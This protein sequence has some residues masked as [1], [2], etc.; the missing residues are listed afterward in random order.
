LS[1]LEAARRLLS[2]AEEALRRAEEAL[3][4]GLYASALSHAHESMEL[5]LKASS[6]VVGVPWHGMGLAERV[7]LLEDWVARGRLSVESGEVR[8]GEAEG[9]VKRARE[10]VEALRRLLSEL[11]EA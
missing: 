2:E 4:R 7:K 8:R 10:A 11:E 3:R 1:L 6:R 5:C 9:E